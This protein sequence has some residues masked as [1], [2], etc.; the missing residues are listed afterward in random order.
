MIVSN[1]RAFVLLQGGGGFAGIL[2]GADF[3]AEIKQ[4]YANAWNVKAGQAAP[5]TGQ[6]FAVYWQSVEAS[7]RVPEVYGMRPEADEFLAWQEWHGIELRHAFLRVRDLRSPDAGWV[8][9]YPYYSAARWNEIHANVRKM[10]D[11]GHEHKNRVPEWINDVKNRYFWRL[12]AEEAARVEAER[13]RLLA[14]QEAARRAAEEA[15]RLEAERLAAL[16]AARIAAQIEAERQAAEAA[17]IEAERLAAQ[18]LAAQQ[19]A[20][21]ARRVAEEEARQAAL[22]AE[23]DT[24]TSQAP[25]LLDQIV[26]IFTPS[27]PVVLVPATTPGNTAIQTTAASAAQTETRPAVQTAS[28][29]G[30]VSSNTILLGTG[31]AVLGIWAMDRLRKA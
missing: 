25:S 3:E 24:L 8:Y 4:R 10:I 16:E 23:A 1:D 31:L 22:R 9:G 7:K 20:E 19:A 5:D 18:Q 11:F 28:A 15:A 27:T 26:S 29:A 12:N 14:E 30:G 6:A 17:R 13:Q 21:E 2:E